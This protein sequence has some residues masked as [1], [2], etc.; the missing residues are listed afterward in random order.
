MGKLRCS[1]EDSRRTRN[2][3][4]VIIKWNMAQYS[5]KVERCVL[6]A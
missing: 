1:T 5:L 2:H 4:V 6:Y 3:G